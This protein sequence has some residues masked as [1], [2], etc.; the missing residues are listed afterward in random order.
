MLSSSAI[1][2]SAAARRRVPSK[3]KGL[4]TATTV[5]WPVARSC[6]ASASVCGKL[7]HESNLQVLRQ[8]DPEPVSKS[9]LIYLESSH[10][11]T[12]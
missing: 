1:I 10:A 6:R 8:C 11:A 12:S 4:V 3:P 7:P 5:N 9:A 2:L